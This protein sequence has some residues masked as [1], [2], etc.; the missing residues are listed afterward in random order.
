MSQ[1]R[2]V[3]KWIARES[4]RVLVTVLGFTLIAGGIVLL[5]LPGPGWLIIFGGLAVLGTQ[6]AWARRALDET[7]RRASSAAKRLRRNKRKAG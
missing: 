2:N 3:V 1:F 4:K 5:P 6:Y 7:K